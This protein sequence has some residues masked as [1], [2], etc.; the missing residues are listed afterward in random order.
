MFALQNDDLESAKALIAFDA[1]I[2]YID[3]KRR[4]TALDIVAIYHNGSELEVLLLLLGAMT[5]DKLNKPP[6]EGAEA[7]DVFHEEGDH[8]DL[9][10]VLGYA[11]ISGASE[12]EERH[13]GHHGPSSKG[14]SSLP[15]G[16]LRFFRPFLI[17]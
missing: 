3:M 8:R 4:Q 6:A 12:H 13:N 15:E 9:A 7:D 5:Y 11:N 17:L 1:K 14:L 10:R 16:N 2:N